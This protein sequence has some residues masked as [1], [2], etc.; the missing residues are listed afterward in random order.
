M[1][2]PH[3]KPSSLEIRPEQEE[4]LDSCEAFALGRRVFRFGWCQDQAPKTHWLLCPVRLLLE[5]NA[6]DL[7]GACVRI[8][9]VLAVP[10]RE[11]QDRSMDQPVLQL[12]EGFRLLLVYGWQ[13]V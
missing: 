9:D 12:L 5:K 2:R 6:P 7:A 13:R 10:P 8:H 4:R 1:V 3:D 11:G